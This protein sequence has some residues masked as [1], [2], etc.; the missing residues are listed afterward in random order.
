MFNRRQKIAVFARN[1]EN[2]LRVR[3]GASK[4]ASIS[5]ERPPAPQVHLPVLRYMLREQA[6][7]QEFGYSH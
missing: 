2:A 6:H 5:V 4:A 1:Y 3:R 7:I